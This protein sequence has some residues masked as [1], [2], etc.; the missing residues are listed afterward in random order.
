VVE[1]G[2][3]TLVLCDDC[4]YAANAESAV[5]QR[6]ETPKEQDQDVEE[7]A[8]P[9]I[10]TIE[11]VAGHLGV[12]PEQTLKAILFMAGEEV[13]FV[14]IRGDLEVNEAK[15]ASGHGLLRHRHGTLDG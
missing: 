1:A 14:I 13:I 5:A 2:E 4:G 9:A 12:K 11:E 10:T 3:D 15:V 8:T 6:T 7:V